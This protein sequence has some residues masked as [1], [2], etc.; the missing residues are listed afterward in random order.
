M[1]T[2]VRSPLRWLI[3]VVALVAACAFAFSVTAGNWWTIGTAEIGPFGTQ[4]CMGGECG[5]RGLAW[6]GGGPTWE[7]AAMATGGAGLIAAL[8]LLIVAGAAAAGRRPRIPA[9]STLAAMVAAGGASAMFI[10]GLPKLGEAAVV[11]RG[12]YLFFAGVVLGVV[13]AVGVLVSKPRS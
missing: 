13:A 7:R 8:I 9:M 10:N 1:C 5:A 2:A 11:E 4:S 12:L 3:V 6:A